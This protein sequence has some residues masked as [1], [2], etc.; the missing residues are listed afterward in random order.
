MKTRAISILL[1]YF[2]VAFSIKTVNAQDKKPEALPDYYNAVASFQCTFKPLEND[3]IDEGHTARILLVYASPN[4]VISFNDSCIFYTAAISF[5]GLDSIRYRIKDN[6][7]GLISEIAKIYI[8]VINESMDTININNISALINP[9]GCLF[10]DYFESNH[11][12]FP[13]G[14]GLST[15]FS[16][17]LNIAAIDEYQNQYLSGILQRQNG[18]DFFPGPVSFE[19]H[20]NYSYDSTWAKVWKLNKYE[21]LTHISSWDQPGYELP[22]KIAGWPGN[23]DPSKG[24]ASM[25]A[26]FH[27]R[28]ENG[29][30]DPL[31]GDYPIIRGDQAVYFIYNDVRATHT[32]FDQ[33]GLQAEI[34]CMVYAFDLPENPALNNTVFINYLVT[35]RSNITYSNMKLSLFADTDNGDAQ[36]DF[37]GCDTLLKAAISFNGQVPDG[38]SGGGGYGDHPPAQ[39]IM[40]LNRD[41]NSFIVNCNTFAGYQWLSRPFIAEEL[42]NNMNAIWNDGSPII[43]SGCGHN[44]CATG[45]V[46]KYAFPGDPNDLDS[47]SML[48]S[49]VGMSDYS[50]FINMAPVVDFQPGETVCIDVALTSAIDENGDH[51]DSYTLVKQYA[52]TVKAFYDANFPAS[53]FDVAP[54]LDEIKTSAHLLNCYPNPAG[55]YLIAEMLN[56]NKVVSGEFLIS[57]LTGRTIKSAKT[58]SAAVSIDVSQLQPGMY[59]I[60]VQ[61]G[62]QRLSAKFIKQ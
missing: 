5:Q 33:N 3:I 51:L 2:F 42:I 45:S 56:V 24:Q 58:S 55:D 22:E 9:Y 4:S 8:N 46:V 43:G 37:V 50:Y 14:S 59:I 7:N 53:C 32:E 34:H 19:E 61:T 44:S 30:Y 12:E 21:I 10:W 38:G 40:L 15:I 54:G 62:N 52:E 57:D 13:K 18:A 27:D 11:Y 49:P 31:N 17:G 60:S 6:Q 26:P 47:W 28:N 23:G 29:I 16:L 35:N 48:Q 39:T 1:L 36:D 20:Y 25:M 41:M